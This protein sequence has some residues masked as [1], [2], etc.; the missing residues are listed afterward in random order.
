ML[1]VSI[2]PC[3]KGSIRLPK[4]NRRKIKGKTLAEISINTAKKI[5]FVNDIILTT[6]DNFLISKLKKRNNIKII[7]RPKILANKKAK[8]VDVVLHAIRAYEKKFNKIDLFILLQPTSPYRSLKKI[9]S[10]FKKMFFYRL[11]KSVVSVS[12][13][14]K[15]NKRFFLIRNN[16]LSLIKKKNINKKIVNKIYQMNGNF[17]ISTTNFIKK[18]KSFFAKQKT[19]PIKFKSKVFST[20][21]DTKKDFI[22][23]KSLSRYIN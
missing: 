9:N 1:A 11:Q 6:D 16:C 4:K 3:R 5:K 22:N 21:I 15:D 14:C 13:E 12:N 18:H 20:D 23:A 8:M 2:I 17:Y 19:L 7:K 10:G